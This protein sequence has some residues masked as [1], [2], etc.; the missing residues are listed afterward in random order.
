MGMKKCIYLLQG[1]SIELHFH[2]NEKKHYKII[3]G[4]K[5]AITNKLCNIGR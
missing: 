2:H 1:S 3:C 5:D 4:D